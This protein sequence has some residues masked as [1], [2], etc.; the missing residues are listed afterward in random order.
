MPIR[1]LPEQLVVPVRLPM[2]QL[3]PTLRPVLTRFLPL[4]RAVSARLPVVQLGPTL[5]PLT[6]VGAYRS[7]AEIG[8]LV[9]LNPES[10]G[11]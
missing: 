9:I 7:W 10:D 8:P 11:K 1:I 4:L 5:R 2:M 3:E 6:S